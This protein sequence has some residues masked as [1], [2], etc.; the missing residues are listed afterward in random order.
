[1]SYR[2]DLAAAHARIETLEAELAR[3]AHEVAGLRS[4][5]ANA[6]HD[7]TLGRVA[8]EE[9]D[10]IK[11]RN[12]APVREPDYDDWLQEKMERAQR[13]VEDELSRRR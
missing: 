5:L 2:D 9:L 6:R 10:E 12:E 4:E 1:V 11:K 7:A 3:A 13:E 8:I